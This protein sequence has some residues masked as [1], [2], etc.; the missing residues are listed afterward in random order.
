MDCHT[1]DEKNIRS[2]KC[3]CC[4]RKQGWI[5]FR[6]SLYCES[7]FTGSILENIVE[8]SMLDDVQPFEYVCRHT[9]LDAEELGRM[10]AV[11]ENYP[12]VCPNRCLRWKE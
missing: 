5:Q 6:E 8:I 1:K 9:N 10:I 4:T 11:T 7:C 3:E 12:L 2:E